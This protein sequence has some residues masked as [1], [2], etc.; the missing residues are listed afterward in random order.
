[1]DELLPFFRLVFALL[2]IGWILLPLVLAFRLRASNRRIEQLT[3]APDKRLQ[4]AIQELKERVGHLETAIEQIAKTVTAESVHR[5]AALTE[6]PP[7][8]AIPEQARTQP[9]TPFIPPAPVVAQESSSVRERKVQIP[10]WRR[11]LRNLSPFLLVALVVLVIFAIGVLDRIE[12]ITLDLRFRSR[13]QTPPHDRIAIIKI[14]EATEGKLGPFGPN[15]RAHHGQLLK[16]LADAGAK[17]VGFDISFPRPSPYDAPMI[18]GIQYAAKKGTSVV[19]ASLYNER[20]GLFSPTVKSI[21]EAVTGIASAHLKKDPLTNLVRFVFPYT[22][23]DKESGPA[24]ARVPSFSY[25]MASLTDQQVEGTSGKTNEPLTINFRGSEL[26]KKIPY[27]EVYEGQFPPDLFKGKTVLVGVTTERAK[28]TFDTPLATLPGV[29]IQAYAL[30]TFLGGKI[31]KLGFAPSS[32]ILLFLVFVSGFLCKK[33]PR[34]VRLLIV[35]TILGVYTTSAFAVFKLDPPLEI[36]LSYGYLAILGTWFAIALE[37][38]TRLR[39]EF[40]QALGLPE[41]AINRFEKE[42]SLHPGP[43]QK[44]LT[45]FESDIKGY[46]SWVEQSSLSQVASTMHEYTQKVEEIIYRH[47]GWVNQYVGDAVLAV[48]GYPFSEANTAERAVA[49]AFEIQKAFGQFKDR[50]KEKGDSMFERVRIGISTGPVNLLFV[51]G[52]KKKRLGIQGTPINLAARL[53][54]ASNSVECAALVSNEVFEQL[55]G[56]VEAELVFV[57]LKN[58]PEIKTAYALKALTL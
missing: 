20:E 47:G 9:A 44:P 24:V 40:G 25:R 23:A 32:G 29:E 33:A 22:E 2:V 58:L 37:E 34:R 38:K 5:S 42:S 41:W 48:F 45:I 18:E 19:V 30:A 54:G 10:H 27:A 4:E 11:L 53:E 21:E 7:P 15:Y 8:E 26:F 52:G 35:A 43:I 46:T 3:S 55:K 31:H 16:T 51:G 12:L 17:A 14:D 39:K 28:D 49:A 57:E 6:A 36:N 50:T 1:M 56:K 13:G